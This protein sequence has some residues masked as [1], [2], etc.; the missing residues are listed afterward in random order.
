M[1]LVLYIGM[2]M[3]EWTARPRRY[4]LFQLGAITPRIYILALVVLKVRR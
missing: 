4:A 1:S 3:W 2:S